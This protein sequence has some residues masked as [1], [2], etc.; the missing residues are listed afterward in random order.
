MMGN[1]PVLRQSSTKVLFGQ[2]RQPSICVIS[3]TPGN[4]STV[5]QAPLIAIKRG[6]ISDA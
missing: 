2:S 1:I 4:D 6:V 3:L 5:G